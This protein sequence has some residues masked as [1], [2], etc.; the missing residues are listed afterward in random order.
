[1]SLIALVIFAAPDPGEPAPQP[2]LPA[3]L[4]VAPWADLMVDQC[5]DKLMAAGLT[6][7]EF[8]LFECLKHREGK[9]VT[10]GELL[11]EVWGTD[12]ADGSNVVDAVVRSLRQK[13]GASAVIVETVRGS[14]Y[15]LRADWRAQLR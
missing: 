11:R 14:G 12:Y 2:E 4:E 6:P 1:M 13:L 7:L 8:G 10:R 15:R 5:K 3:G 9:T